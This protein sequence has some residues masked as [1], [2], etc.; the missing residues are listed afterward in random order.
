LPARCWPRWSA[1]KFSHER[2]REEQRGR[3]ARGQIG[4]GSPARGGAEGAA[5]I[6]GCGFAS[7]LHGAQRL[8]VN[9]ARIT[10][11]NVLFA[12]VD[13]KRARQ[14]P[15]RTM[16]AAALHQSLWIRPNLAAKSV[17]FW[18]IGDK[19]RP[20]GAAVGSMRLCH[21]LSGRACPRVCLPMLSARRTY[22]RGVKDGSRVRRGNRP[23]QL[24]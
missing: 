18:S 15:V 6:R 3:G 22:T 23:R 1:R 24:L 20:I 8:R 9:D 12:L 17:A 4:G 21:R 19:G 5:P 13:C 10:L 7:I 11:G 2:A 14:F 16:P